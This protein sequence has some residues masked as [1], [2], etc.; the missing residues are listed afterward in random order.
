M[1]FRMILRNAVM[2]DKWE[3]PREASFSHILPSML[4]NFRGCFAP[5]ECNNTITIVA[6][7][8]SCAECT[9]CTRAIDDRL[10]CISNDTHGYSIFSLLPIWQHCSVRLRV[11]T[12][13]S[14]SLKT[15]YHHCCGSTRVKMTTGQKSPN[16]A[17]CM[18]APNQDV[19]TSI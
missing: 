1:R 8:L 7:A 15:R 10:P 17:C 12:S 6:Q 16:E 18:W 3:R 13:I 11:Y 2:V 5:E 19:H 4:R 14:P 9:G